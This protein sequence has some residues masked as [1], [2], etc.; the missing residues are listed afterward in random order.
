MFATVAPAIL[1]MFKI[2][3]AAGMDPTAKWAWGANVGW[4]N[5]SPTG[6]G[7]T[8]EPGTGSFIG[9]AWGENLGWISFKGG[10]GGPRPMGW[11]PILAKSISPW[12]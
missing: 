6:G 10:S 1:G 9:F 11:S 3:S 8:I 7:V 5:F 12:S 2:T 4:V